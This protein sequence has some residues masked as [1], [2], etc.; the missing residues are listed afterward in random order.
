MEEALTGQLG[1]QCLPGYQ[2]SREQ[3][4]CEFLPTTSTGTGSG[5]GREKYRNKTNKKQC[6]F[7]ITIRNQCHVTNQS[8]ADVCV[9]SSVPSA[10][11]PCLQRVCHAQASCV[12]IGPNQHLCACNNGYSG[13]GRVCMAVDP[14]Q[15][16]YGGCSA[17]S[18]RCVYDGPGKVRKY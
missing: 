15:T 10:I 5:S 8:H 14:C 1:C 13:D 9:F 12:H 7:L 6:L 4:L 17:E 18:T 3:C 11:N 16:K 2:K